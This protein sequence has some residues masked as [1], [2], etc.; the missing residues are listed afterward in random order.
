MSSEPY[1]IRPAVIEDYDNLCKIMHIVDRYHAEQHPERF[2]SVSEGRAW[3]LDYIQGIL[4]N[5]NNQIFLAELA[6]T[7]VG[8]IVVF[9]I[10]PPELPIFIQDRFASI[11]NLGVL[12]QARRLG[13]GKALMKTAER[14]A[15]RHG[16]KRIDLSVY[17]FNQ[18]A[19]DLYDALG[20]VA[21]SQKMSKPVELENNASISDAG[22]I[23]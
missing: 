2:R 20:Y 13:I 7:P 6:A 23:E 3:S 9:V 12:T 19:I 1:L 11:E 17:L 8:Y 21:V 10:D 4:D 5:P 18:P 22:A 15:A 14:W 16:A